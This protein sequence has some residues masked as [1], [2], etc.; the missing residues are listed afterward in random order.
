MYFVGA[1]EQRGG[2]EVGGHCP[3]G[4]RQV[5]NSHWSDPTMGGGRL[6]LNP[7]FLWEPPTGRKYL[8]M[9]RPTIFLHENLW[10]GQFPLVRSHNGRRPAYCWTLTFCGSLPLGGSTWIWKDRQYFCMKIFGMVN[11]HW[12]DP[13]MGGG[14]PIVVP[15]SHSHLLWESNWQYFC[16]KSRWSDLTMGASWQ[17]SIVPSLFVGG[18]S[19]E[20]NLERK[21][22]KQYHCMEIFGMLMANS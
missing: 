9:K 2:L 4:C 12:S 22:N 3:G 6:L 10:H 20:Q 14:R 1:S 17:R 8:N 13:T 15:N 21:T 5:N 16:T 19:S 11:F 18:S 7:H